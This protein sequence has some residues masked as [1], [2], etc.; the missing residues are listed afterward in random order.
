MV[1]RK[2]KKITK[3]TKVKEIKEEIP[4]NVGVT[5]PKKGDVGSQIAIVTE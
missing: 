3:V 4:E 5:P 2:I 1:K